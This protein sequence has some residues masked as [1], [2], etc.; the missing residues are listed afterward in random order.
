MKSRSTPPIRLALLATLGAFVLLLPSATFAKKHKGKGKPPTP[1]VQ[2]CIDAY[3]KAQSSAQDAKLRAAKDSLAL[4]TK[5]ACPAIM[6]QE[7]TN[8]YMQLD[9]DIPSVIPVV[10]D[11][12]GTPRSLVEVRMDGELLTSKLDGHALPVDPGKHDFEFNTDGGVFAKKSVMIVQG[13]R[14]RPISVVYHSGKKAGGEVAVTNEG[15]APEEGSKAESSGGGAAASSASKS[16]PSEAAVAQANEEEEPMPRV[17]ATRSVRRQ[18]A[19]SSE[20]PGILTYV[21]AGIGVA[22]V[23]GYFLMSSWGRKDNDKLAACAPACDVASVDHVNKVYRAAN[24]S[25]I[26]GLAALAT[27]GI[28]FYR[29]QTATEEVAAAPLAPKARTHTASLRMVDIQPTPAGG[30]VATVGGAF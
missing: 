8:R 17:T 20:G 3:K 13:Q 30:A 10:T 6:R 1:E 21:T 27:S 16:S 19:A 7:C 5:P 15:A 23:T 29:S 28:L 25:G 24:I 2:A 11:D 4:C 22:G 14:N 12:S 9:S 18:A 26:V